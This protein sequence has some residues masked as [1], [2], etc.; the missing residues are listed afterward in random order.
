MISYC[1]LDCSACEEYLATQANNET[2]LEKIARQWTDSKKFR[3]NVSPENVLCDGCK[4]GKRLSFHCS[5]T[6]IIKKCCQEKNLSTCAECE[7]YPCE[8]EQY[9]FD[10]L[11]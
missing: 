4:S 10:K 1:G 8:K 11:S 3:V 2:E 9:L 6:C 5:E 7:N